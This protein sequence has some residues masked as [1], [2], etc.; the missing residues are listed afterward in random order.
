VA[1]E[2]VSLRVT[3]DAALQILA[4]SLPVVQEKPLLG[5]MK[6]DAAEATGRN[7]PRADMAVGAELGLIV[8]LAAGALPAVGGN[9]V[10]GQETTGVITGWSV[11][12][13]RPVTLETGG[14]S[15]ARGTAL[16]SSRG[17]CCMVLGKVQS[18]GLRSPPLGL[19]PLPAPRCGGRDRLYRGRRAGVAGQ[20]ALLGVTR[21]ATGCALADLPAVLAQEC[22]ICMTRRGFECCLDRQRPW[23]PGKRLD[24]ADLRCVHVTL[25]AEILGMARGTG[26]CDRPHGAG[27][28]PVL[29]GRKSGLAVRGR[30]R[31]V[32]YRCSGE[33]NGLRQREVTGGAGRVRRLEVG[34]LDSVAGKAVGHNRAP[35]LHPIGPGGRVAGAT[36]KHGISRRLGDELR[37]LLVGEPQIART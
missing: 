22:R 35:H 31:K 29:P 26:S 11:G 14:P 6:A 32:A 12:R 2:A 19:C 4:G 34:G 27:Q 5:I 8:A 3:G 20:A 17:R 37:M 1:G 24:G 25:G 21:G 7:Q 15:M 30:R 23:I 18:V 36:G 9:R 16:R 13:A 28:L 33:L 10:R